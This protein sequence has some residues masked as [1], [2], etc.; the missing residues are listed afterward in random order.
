MFYDYMVNPNIYKKMVSH[1]GFMT[2][3]KQFGFNL[4]ED[5]ATGVMFAN[6]T[7]PSK[8]ECG[9]RAMLHQ[10]L[11]MDTEE[12]ISTLAE[13]LSNLNGG[14]QIHLASVYQEASFGWYKPVCKEEIQAMQTQLSERMPGLEFMLYD[15][16]EGEN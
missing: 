2:E 1:F 12:A 6:S 4:Y 14:T 7:L 8:N 5:K 11:G 9:L 15:Y 13:T 3:E 10:Q 16:V